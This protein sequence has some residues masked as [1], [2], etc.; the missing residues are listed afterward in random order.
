MAAKH[1]K[2]RVANRQWRSHFPRRWRNQ[3]TKRKTESYEFSGFRILSIGINSITVDFAYW[4]LRPAKKGLFCCDSTHVFIL[5][6]P[7]HFTNFIWG[8]SILLFSIINKVDFSCQWRTIVFIWQKKK[9]MVARRYEISLLLF[10]SLVS[11]RVK[12][13]R[14]IP[15]LCA[16]MYYSLS[17]KWHGGQVWCFVHRQRTW[18]RIWFLLLS[19]RLHTSFWTQDKAYWSFSQEIFVT[20]SPLKS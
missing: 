10:S 15:Y 19:H 16:S 1:S 18:A 5:S 2:I 8:L 4:E 12:N 20:P 6:A 3:N 14:E 7:T 13:S 17:I 9:C 11:Y